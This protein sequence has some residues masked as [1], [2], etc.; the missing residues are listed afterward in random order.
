M[1]MEG[2]EVAEDDGRGCEAEGDIIG[3]RVKLLT[4]GRGY[5]EQTGH[6]TVEE[7]KDSSHNNEQ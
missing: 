6:H 1:N 4:D 3:Q 7:V 5:M 2:G